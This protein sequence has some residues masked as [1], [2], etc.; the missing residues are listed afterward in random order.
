VQVGSVGSYLTA[1]D[2][3]TGQARWRHRFYSNGVGGGGLLA[4]AGGLIF[5]GDGSSSLAAYDA[6]NG[7]ALWNTRIGRVSNAPQTFELDGH[8]YVIC[9]SGDTLWSFILH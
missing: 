1:I 3:K 6:A 9:A 8:Q 4:T 7:K 5:T 2:Y